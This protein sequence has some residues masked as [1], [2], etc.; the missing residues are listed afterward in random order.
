[1]AK[2]KIFHLTRKSDNSDHLVRASRAGDALAIVAGNRWTTR[3]ASA[4]DIFKHFSAGGQLHEASVEEE[5]GTRF[6][7]LEPTSDPAAASV[8][9]RAK[10]VGD[11][12]TALSNNDV[13]IDVVADETLVRLL[14]QGVQVISV[15]PKEKKSAKAAGASNDDG[16]GTGTGTDTSTSTSSD[17][18][19][20]AALA[21]A[22]KSNAIDAAFAELTD[23]ASPAATTSTE[24]D[25]AADGSTAAA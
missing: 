22:N 8:L 20:A 24:G 6:V 2:E 10:N 4:D 14:G 7:Y 23:Q 18:G 13:T 19:D 15:P 12:L 5:K 9:I 25:A 16:T 1:M 21:E 11:A 17:E 3:V